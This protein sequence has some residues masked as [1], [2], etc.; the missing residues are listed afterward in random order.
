MELKIRSGCRLALSAAIIL[1]AACFTTSAQAKDGEAT[2]TSSKLAERVSAKGDI[3]QV[4]LDRIELQS[5]HC[6]GG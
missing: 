4:D 2:I 6:S 1:L 5:G 3:A